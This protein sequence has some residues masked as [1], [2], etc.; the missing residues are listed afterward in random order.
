[1]PGARW[2]RLGREAA[3]APPARA[4]GHGA[5]TTAKAAAAKS[6]PPFRPARVPRLARLGSHGACPR[7]VRGRRRR[8]S[9]T[10]SGLARHCHRSPSR[11]AQRVMKWP[12]RRRAVAPLGIRPRR[13]IGAK[14]NEG[15]FTW[16]KF[17]PKK[18]KK[19]SPFGR[20]ACAVCD[21]SWRPEGAWGSARRPRGRSCPLSAPRTR[22]KG[23]P[24]GAAGSCTAAPG[25][26]S[27]EPALQL[28]LLGPQTPRCARSSRTDRPRCTLRPHPSCSGTGLPLPAPRSRP[29]CS[30]VR[31]PAAAAA[32]RERPSRSP[33]GRVR[34]RVDRE[35]SYLSPVASFYAK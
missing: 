19:K 9:C 17:D 12:R 20:P 35:F 21:G 2:R 27:Q 18:K 8:R 15:R 14:V 32:R 26:E 23:V 31:S 24:A 5:G 30:F 3:A 13:A 7:P 33:W 11:H 22:R 6:G 1:M 34:L 29:H 28:G 16:P 10:S 4:R 25:R